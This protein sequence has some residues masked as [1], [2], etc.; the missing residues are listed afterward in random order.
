MCVLDR[1]SWRER[2]RERASE[3]GGGQFAHHLIGTTKGAAALALYRKRLFTSSRLFFIEPW[4]CTFM[5]SVLM[6]VRLRCASCFPGLW[7]RQI[8]YRVDHVGPDNSCYRTF[9]LRY[10]PE[11]W[12]SQGESGPLRAVHLLR[13]KWPGGVSQLRG[14]L[15]SS[16]RA[17]ALLSD[18]GSAAGPAQGESYLL[19]TYWSESTLSS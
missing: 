9:H 5:L 1:E 11:L 4:R 15:L 18:G 17:L 14:H 16:H 19:T 12:V 13:H 7:Y 8:S 3:R 10:Q 6:C 2:E